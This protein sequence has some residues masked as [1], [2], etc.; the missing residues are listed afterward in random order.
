MHEIQW[1]ESIEELL[2]GSSFFFIYLV[3]KSCILFT[4]SLQEKYIFYPLLCPY[5]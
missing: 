1:I 5:L 3:K 4:Y 2:A